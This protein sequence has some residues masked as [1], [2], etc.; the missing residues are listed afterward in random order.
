MTS[1]KHWDLVLENMDA[2][3]KLYALDLRGFGKLK[4]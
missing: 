2:E 1:S 3:Y 4:L